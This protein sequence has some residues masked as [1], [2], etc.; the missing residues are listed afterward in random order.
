MKIK[1]YS[2]PATKKYQQNRFQCRECPYQKE[3]EDYQNVYYW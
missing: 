3:M 1:K 2:A